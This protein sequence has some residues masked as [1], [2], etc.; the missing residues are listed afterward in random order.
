MSKRTYIRS[1]G[2]LAS[3]DPAVFEK[4][5]GASIAKASASTNVLDAW[6]LFIEF[7]LLHCRLRLSC[8]VLPTPPRVYQ[9]CL[10]LLNAFHG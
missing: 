6:T 1:F 5:T 2:W 10:I 8:A 7:D 9:G 4:E 3:P